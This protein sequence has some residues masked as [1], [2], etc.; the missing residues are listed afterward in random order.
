MVFSTINKIDSWKEER[1]GLLWVSSVSEQDGC[2]QEGMEYKIHTLRESSTQ[3]LLF[4]IKSGFQLRIYITHFCSAIQNV[5]NDIH[6]VLNTH[7]MKGNIWASPAVCSN[8]S[9]SAPQPAERRKA[10]LRT[11]GSEAFLFHVSFS[12]QPTLVCLTDRHLL[13]QPEQLMKT[14]P[15]RSTW[16]NV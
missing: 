4:L 15:S 16:E 6:S 11:R 14:N 1:A 12:L 8:T 13:H 10:S 3:L 5:P 7:E 9:L 2:P